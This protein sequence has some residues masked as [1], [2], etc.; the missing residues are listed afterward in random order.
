[1]TRLAIFAALAALALAAGCA[2]PASGTDDPARDA[3][4]RSDFSVYDL[5]SRWRDQAGATLSLG[6][7]RGRPRVLAMIYTHCEATC[8]LTVAD[9]KR[10]EAATPP[11]V[12][13][14]LVSL[15]PERD[16]TGRLAEYAT[17]HGLDR[18]RWTLLTGRDTDVQDLAAA[19]GARYRRRS[20][21]ELAHS[22]TLTVLD[23]TGAVV[24][25][26]PGIDNSDETIRAVRALV[27]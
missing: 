25:Q 15:D 14:V 3:P 6:G 11:A 7:L 10:I 23:S 19:L 5:G 2:R 24:H 21:T 22:N 16:S 12:G 1:M 26:Q 9:L 8:P 4:E 18:A 20:A 17:A 27:H 13:F